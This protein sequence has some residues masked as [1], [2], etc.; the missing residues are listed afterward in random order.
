MCLPRPLFASFCLCSFF[1]KRISIKNVIFSG[2]WTR[3][4]GIRQA[5]W[6][7]DHHHRTNLIKLFIRKFDLILL[8]NKT[9][10]DKLGKEL[11][12][13]WC[14]RCRCRCRCRCHCCCRCCCCYCCCY[15][16]CCCCCC[17][18]G[19]WPVAEEVVG[20]PALTVEHP[21]HLVRKTTTMVNN[22]VFGSNYFAKQTLFLVL[23]LN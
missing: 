10:K 20:F 19:P 13:F 1:S 9:R 4:I 16:S 17:R 3:I 11:R 21:S 5:L 8:L 12:A 18:S 2:I 14:C 23:L 22:W 7:L 15:W 6:P